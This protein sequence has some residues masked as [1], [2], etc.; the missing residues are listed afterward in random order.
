MYKWMIAIVLV[1]MTAALGQEVQER[2][3]FKTPSAKLALRRHQLAVERAVVQFNRET[4]KSRDVLVRQLE[5]SLEQVI[6]AK[7][8]DEALLLRTAIDELKK[9][10]PLNAPNFFGIPTTVAQESGKATEAPAQ[11]TV[12]AKA[13]A[14]EPEREAAKPYVGSAEE[15]NAKLR[16]TRWMAFEH[17]EGRGWVHLNGDHTLTTGFHEHIGMWAAIDGQ[18]VKLGCWKDRNDYATWVITDKAATRGVNPEAN[19]ASSK[20]VRRL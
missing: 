2:W 4:A 15:L 20:H 10:Q 3:Q 1:A 6:T 13:P 12:S 14:Q 18:T 9:E 17:P 7:N 8:L 16:G 19:D 11:T 5:E